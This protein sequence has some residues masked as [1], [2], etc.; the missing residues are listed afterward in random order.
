MGYRETPGE[1]Y[2]FEVLKNDEGGYEVYL[3]HQ[4]D[5]WKV[6][7][8]DGTNEKSGFSEKGWKFKGLP[9]QGTY[10]G[11]PTSKEFAVKQME[12]FVQRAQ[13]AL[14]RLKNLD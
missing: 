8:F 13:E 10:P 1:D 5:D 11:H 6:L 14:E 9:V 7:G 12:L 2:E 4:C 3:P